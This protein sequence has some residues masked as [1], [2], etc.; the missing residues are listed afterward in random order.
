[1]IGFIIYEGVKTIFKG[2]YKYLL[3]FTYTKEGL[4]SVKDR[5]IYQFEGT[6]IILEKPNKLNL[7]ML[8]ELED[9]IKK[10]KKYQKKNFLPY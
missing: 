6:K 4:R 1:M 3:R 8:L 10:H 9:F 7:P 2:T 5:K